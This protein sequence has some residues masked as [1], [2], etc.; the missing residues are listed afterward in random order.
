MERRSIY[1]LSRML[2]L[3]KEKEGKK[4]RHKPGPEEEVLGQEEETPDYRMGIS[5][6]VNTF[7]RI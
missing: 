5:A 3:N 6:P 4:E 2:G 7:I 1:T